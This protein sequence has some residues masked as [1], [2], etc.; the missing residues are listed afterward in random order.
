MEKIQVSAIQICMLC[1][2][3]LQCSVSE[4]DLHCQC[5][6]FNFPSNFMQTYLYLLISTHFFISTT[7]L[8]WVIWVF[9]K[10]VNPAFIGKVTF[11]WAV[12]LCNLKILVN[13]T[14]IGKAPF[15]KGKP[16]NCEMNCD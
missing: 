2:A 9:R 8:H 5:I 11:H 14:S 15:Y 13:P 6:F 1:I 16:F 3:L 7:N 12:Y 10:L 4:G